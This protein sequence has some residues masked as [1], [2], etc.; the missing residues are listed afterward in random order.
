MTKGK[1][2]EAKGRPQKG[3]PAFSSGFPELDE[4]YRSVS[5]TLYSSG[6]FRPFR[7]DFL[8]HAGSDPIEEP[9]PGQEGVHRLT[10]GGQFRFLRAHDKPQ[11]HVQSR[12]VSGWKEVPHEELPERLRPPP[13]FND[14]EVRS[15]LDKVS[16]VFWPVA[17]SSPSDSLRVIFPLLSTIW[18]QRSDHLRKTHPHLFTPREIKEFSPYLRQVV[19][20]KKM[21]HSDRAKMILERR[22]GLYSRKTGVSNYRY[23]IKCWWDHFV[24]RDLFKTIVA[25][26]GSS[27]SLQLNFASYASFTTLPNLDEVVQ[28]VRSMGQ[29]RRM[30]KAVPFSQWSAQKALQQLPGFSPKQTDRLLALPRPMKIELTTRMDDLSLLDGLS[31][32]LILDILEGVARHRPVLRD[33]QLAMSAMAVIALAEKAWGD[34]EGFEALSFDSHNKRER[35][36]Q[37][38]SRPDI[39]EL[40][41]DLVQLWRKVYPDGY[42]AFSASRRNSFLLVALTGL[43]TSPEGRLD[44]SDVVL[45]DPQNSRFCLLD[46]STRQLFCVWAPKYYLEKM[47]PRR[48]RGRPRKD[49][50]NQKPLMPASP[51]PAS[52]PL[53]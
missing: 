22:I 12:G 21:S 15:Q 23:A 42:A 44:F 49:Q 13:S 6:W 24:D 39:S 50:K 52:P 18:G 30:L 33:R 45:E 31:P 53:M 4:V 41:V 46:N 3:R 20:N 47:L 1:N 14:Q 9:S 28:A 29:E 40:L 26:S 8:P 10:I 5:K 37:T 16:P 17:S 51:I 48:G 36:I 32:E 7:Y 34:P 27:A 11:V 25:V 38:L 2:N 43:A 35:Y 19:I